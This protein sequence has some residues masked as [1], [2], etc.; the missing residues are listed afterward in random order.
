MKKIRKGKDIAIRWAILTNGS[1]EPL[2]GR[3]LRV[4]LKD[5]IGHVSI[6]D[7][8]V[9]GSTLLMWFRGTEQTRYGVHRLTLWEN[10]GKTGQTVVDNCNAFA[11][12]KCTDE[13]GDCTSDEGLDE[14]TLNIKSNIAVGVAGKDGYTPQK[15]VD[16]NDGNDGITPHINPDNHHWMIGYIDTGILAEGT[17]RFE[18]LT[19]EQKASL[20]GDK[21]DKGEQGQPGEPGAKGEKG[22]KGDKGDKGQDADIE[23]ATQATK[24]ANNAAQGAETVN[25]AIEGNVVIVTDRNGN[26]TT[27]VIDFKYV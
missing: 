20:K 2:E 3:D 22:D 15:G 23:A 16:Y 18:D 4:E 6:M 10:Y 11:L 17:M 7:A 27:K 8:T 26:V 12:V 25:I 1:A 14:E 21:G 24:R 9:D 5:P 19:P 13:E